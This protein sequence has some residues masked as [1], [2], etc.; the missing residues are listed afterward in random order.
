MSVTAYNHNSPSIKRIFRE[1]AEMQSETDTTVHA[2]PLEDNVFEWHFTVKGPEDSEFEGGIYHGRLTLPPEYP[3]KPPSIMLLTP[4]G[5]FEVNTKIC[6]NASGY[7]PEEWKPSWSIKTLLV[8]LRSFM[9]TSGK[10]AIGAVDASPED[11]KILAK[12]S[13]D[14]KCQRCGSCNSH[15]FPPTPAPIPTQTFST[16]SPVQLS[17]SV[18]VQSTTRPTQLTAQP[19]AQPTTQLT[20]QPNAQ[21]P[22][23]SNVQA[24]SQPTPAHNASTIQLAAPPAPTIALAGPQHASGAV[25]NIMTL[26]DGLLVIVALCIGILLFRKIT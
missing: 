19:P 24:N 18:H 3:L 22:T 1:I 21:P 2:A 25:S 9:T 17:Q 20:A 8:A 16:S 23:L 15:V 5:R 4:N 13:L 12:R 26:L 10:G 14:W 11:R 6:L 7:H